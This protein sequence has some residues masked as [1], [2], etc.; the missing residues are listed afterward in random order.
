MRKIVF[1]LFA[2]VCLAGCGNDNEPTPPTNNDNSNNSS[3]N[4]ITN[5]PSN[6]SNN[7]SYTRTYSTVAFINESQCSSYKYYIDDVYITELLPGGWYEYKILSG[8]HNIKSIQSTGFPSSG[9]Y[10]GKSVKF[11]D[12]IRLKGDELFKYSLTHLK[13]DLTFTNSDTSHRY[14]ITVNDGKCITPFIIKSGETITLYQ[15]D[16]AYYNIKAEQLDWIL[17]PSDYENDIYLD[18]NKTITY[19]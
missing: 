7:P 9:K 17:Y 13:R 3:N 15:L 8:T 4:D 19:K 5:T 10:A 18:N 2:A 6:P 11:S 12:D 1:I 14:R 16:C